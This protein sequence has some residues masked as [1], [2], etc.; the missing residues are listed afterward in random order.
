MIAL[1][2]AADR[3]QDIFVPDVI[4]G[5][6]DSIQDPDYWGIKKTFS[7][8][9]D[10]ESPYEGRWD[11]LV[12]PMKD[13]NRSDLMKAIEFSDQCGAR[14]ILIVNALGGRTD[15]LLANIRLL[16]RYHRPDRSLQI[17]A[18]DEVLEFVRDGEFVIPAPPGA[19]FSVMAFPDAVVSS[20][21]LAFEL[22]D[23][24]L[25]FGGHE[26][27]CNRIETAGACITVRGEAL[28][29]YE[30]REVAFSPVRG[31]TSNSAIAF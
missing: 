24:H 15:H 1:D 18:V 30:V 20:R 2:G 3:F 6:L 17:R 7:E 31:V 16:R 8:L 5:D 10:V 4:L 25:E 9:S 13:Q 28:A 21:G 26:T 27:I 22:R 14:S 29:I 19:R 11:L 12:V 23:D